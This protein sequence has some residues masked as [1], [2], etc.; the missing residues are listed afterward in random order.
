MQG[1]CALEDGAASERDGGEEGGEGCLVGVAADKVTESGEE[2]SSCMGV[3]DV[4]D[5]LE[6]RRC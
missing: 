3:V 1:D 6:G 4:C 2:L 5:L